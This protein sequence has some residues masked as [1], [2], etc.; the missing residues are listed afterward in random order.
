M[1]SNRT[2]LNDSDPYLLCE[3]GT[4][5]NCFASLKKGNQLMSYRFKTVENCS[6]Y[7]EFTE[8]RHESKYFWPYFRKQNVS[9]RNLQ[10]LISLIYMRICNKQYEQL[11]TYIIQLLKWPT[12]FK[13]CKLIITSYQQ[14]INICRTYLKYKSM[15]FSFK[16]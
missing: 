16:F 12:M 13:V 11:I 6:L 9:Q 15:V 1:T 4:T 5:P 14:F 7:P 3:D 2:M 10:I 8:I